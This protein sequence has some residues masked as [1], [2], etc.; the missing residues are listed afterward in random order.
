MGFGATSGRGLES[1]AAPYVWGAVILV[2]LLLWLWF[3]HDIRKREREE[4]ARKDRE[5]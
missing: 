2:A 3:R 5:D 1:A 4:K